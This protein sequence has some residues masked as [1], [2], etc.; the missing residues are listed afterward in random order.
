M[1]KKRSPEKFVQKNSQMYRGSFSY[2]V[3]GNQIDP[4]LGPEVGNG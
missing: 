1:A 2:L 3:F 4:F